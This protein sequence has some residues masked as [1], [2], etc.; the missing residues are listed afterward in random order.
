MRGPLRS[1]SS[2]ALV[3]RLA[4]LLF[5]LLFLLSSKSISAVSQMHLVSL[6]TCTL[7][8]ATA[9]EL[10]CRPAC[11]RRP[12]SLSLPFLASSSTVLASRRSIQGSS[13]QSTGGAFCTIKRLCIT[14][15]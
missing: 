14:Q 2:I 5:F 9:R 10:S 3:L 8:P 6:Q 7:S 15:S 11:L 13:V 12:A 1:A 4:P